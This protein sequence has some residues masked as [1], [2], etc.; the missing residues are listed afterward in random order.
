[1]FI[2]PPLSSSGLAFA[3]SQHD[4]R[5]H[6]S[7]G[8][9]LAAQAP[10]S[11][12]SRASG[13]IAAAGGHGRLLAPLERMRTAAPNESFWAEH[14]LVNNARS[15]ALKYE[16]AKTRKLKGVLIWMLNGCTQQEAP[17]LWRGLDSAFGKRRDAAGGDRV[18]LSTE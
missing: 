18:A 2:A 15:L 1:M 9:F 7:H 8:A 4:S 5:P 17:E 12:R 16:Q 11:P 14:M 13:A 10:S 6:T 3:S